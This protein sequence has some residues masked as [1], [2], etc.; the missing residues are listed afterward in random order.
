[1][2]FELLAYRFFAGELFSQY[3]AHDK[4]ALTLFEGRHVEVFLPVRQTAQTML[5]QQVR[6]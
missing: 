2:H 3:A 6:F 4:L 5:S 1:V